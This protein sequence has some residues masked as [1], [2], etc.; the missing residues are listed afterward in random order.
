MG[1]NSVPDRYVEINRYAMRRT[2]EELKPILELC[3][4]AGKEMRDGPENG[5]RS[6]TPMEKVRRQGIVG[7][8]Q[9]GAPTTPLPPEIMR[10]DFAWAN[11]RPILRTAMLV[12]FVWHP[13]LPVEAQAREFGREIGRRVSVDAFGDYSRAGLEGTY[14][15][16]MS[17]I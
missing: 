7:A 12:K 17:Q 15:V 5:W 14:A 6:M 2:E 13:H 10:V 16:Y 11:L 3:Y 1:G 8:A 4:R 9:A